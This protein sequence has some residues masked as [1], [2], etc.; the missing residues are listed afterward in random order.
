MPMTDQSGP[1][2]THGETH[3]TT[4][5]AAAE[6]TAAEIS[7]ELTPFRAVNLQF[8][9]AAKLLG[10]SDDLSV[11]LKTPHREVMVEIPLR[12]S[13]GSLR[14]FRGYRVQ[15][16]NSRG[17]MK[18]GLRYH[19]EVD[20]DEVRALASLMTWKTAVVDIPYGG[21][22]G[23]IACDPRQLSARDV[24][25]LTRM[26]ITR[27]EKFIGPQDDIPA[28]DVN[29]NPQVMAWIVDEYA[30]YHGFTPGVVTGKPVEL[31]GSL[32][33]TSATGRGVLFAAERA[34]ADI[35]ISLSGATVAVQ[36]FGN[37]GSWAAHFLAEAGARIVA[38]SDV[39][40]AIYSGDGLDVEA[41]R[42]AVASSGSVLDHDGAEQISNEELLTLDVDILVPAALGGVL[43]RDNAAD[44]RA[45]LIV[46]GANHP[47]TPT[48]DHIFA[49]RGIT[50]VPDIYANAGGVTVSYFEW[51]QNLQQ[52]RWPA[53]RVD[54]ELRRIMDAAYDT[55][56]EVAEEY[57]TDLRTA[58][59][60]MA[61]RRVAE[62]TRLRGQS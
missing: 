6:V 53:E 24:E 44:V 14:T 28:P 48:A 19:P 37:V 12:C 7:E 40:G 58:A 30:K 62:A 50:V 13:D 5:G 17:P 46:E 31:G 33:R 18:G 32:G 49:E 16:D 20:L 45:K 22:K 39:N 57:D 59:F 4:G 3:H 11:A 25:R 61:I 55:L 51:V 29:T 47:T 34:G 38:V 56:R 43:H 36:G 42:E 8:D 41:L 52:F 15:H 27:I 9:R 54:T 35:G 1:Q 2:T 23:G 26:F 60:T 10:L 21:A